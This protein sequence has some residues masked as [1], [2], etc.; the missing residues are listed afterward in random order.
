MAFALSLH[1][2]VPAHCPVSF[3]AR[4]YRRC[5]FW[6]CYILDRFLA[7]GSRRPGLISDDCIKIE[8]PRAQDELGDANEFLHSFLSTP[9]SMRGVHHMAEPYGRL[10]EITRILGLADKYLVAGG[11]KSDS[12]YHWHEHSMLSRVR[13]QLELWA[14]A[15]QD[16]FRSLDVIF[17][18][19]E[20]VILALSRL[21]Y[22]LVYCLIYRSFM[23]IDLEELSTS[24]Q[25]PPW[26]IE[27]M[28]LC[29]FH[30]N[31]IPELIDSWKTATSKDIP[32]FAAYCLAVAGTVH[33]HGHYYRGERSGASS[34]SKAFLKLEFRH[35][36]EI[37][38]EWEGVQNQLKHLQT[39]FKAHSEVIRSMAGGP[40]LGA[41]YGS[42]FDRYDDCI[43]DGAFLSLEV[44]APE[45]R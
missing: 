45:F 11:P 8:P 13:H 14:T 15:T 27:A 34:S 44:D 7:S 16:T 36:A 31:A 20:S 43:P 3:A 5:L 24:G 2:E 18:R 42:F 29:F 40:L 1:C 30:G 4:E 32:A 28:N 41:S 33:V 12:H 19:P 39:I 21:V 35:L 6:T 38:R 17:G 37:E 25:D 9:Q 26:R 22:H 10:I 23:P